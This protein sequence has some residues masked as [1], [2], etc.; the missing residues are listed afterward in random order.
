M[1]FSLIF[2]D[3]RQFHPHHPNYGKTKIGE[4]PRGFSET[5]ASRTRPAP[6]LGEHPEGML[7]HIGCTT[8]QIEEMREKQETWRRSAE[9]TEGLNC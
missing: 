8:D 6:E 7:T 2:P 4:L 3:R 9:G 5:Q 1:S